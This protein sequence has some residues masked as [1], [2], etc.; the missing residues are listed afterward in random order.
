MTAPER[1]ESPQI[2]A[3]NFLGLVALVNSLRVLG[4]DERIY[5]LDCGFEPWQRAVL[6]QDRAVAVINAESSRHPMLLKVVL[7]LA[8]PAQIM[9]VVDV[10]VIFTGRVDTLADTA[11]TAGKPIFFPD[12]WA[13]RFQP[14]W[15]R[16]GFGRPIPHPYVASGQL[17]LPAECG[18]DFLTLWAQGLERLATDPTLSG[19]GLPKEK[20]P[21]FFPD[22]DVL[23]ALIGPAIPLDSFIIADT[24]SAAYPPFEGVR[25]V[26][27]E[28]LVVESADGSRPILLHH[29]M[30]KPWNHLIAP[31]PYSRLM[32]RL[33]CGDDIALR[34]ARGRI[35]QSLRL[36]V[37]GA[38]GRR[39]VVS[40]LGVRTLRA[41]LDIR[42]RLAH[43]HLIGPRSSTQRG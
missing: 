3:R 30:H 35:P 11:A 10:D 42:A 39:Y 32:T 34:T 5:V 28:R 31:N 20:D 36:G 22:M 27:S 40:R 24:T 19:S 25:I 33:L 2:E 16:L 43:V 21:F 41:K 9:V 23:N 1:P 15:E 18:H 8:H 6:A 12:F 29:F 13:D 7:P 38:V 14:A 4:H 37:H 17:V 26:D